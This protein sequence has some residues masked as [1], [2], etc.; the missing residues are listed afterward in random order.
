[1]GIGP[2]QGQDS[3]TQKMR[4]YIHASGGIGTYNHGV[5]VAQD[6]TRIKPWDTGIG[7]L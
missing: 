4:T 7:Y 2:S 5:R 1:M 3:T 6:Q